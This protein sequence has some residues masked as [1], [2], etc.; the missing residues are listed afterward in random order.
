MKFDKENTKQLLKIIIIGIFVYWILNNLEMVKTVFGNI[1]NVLFPFILGC[2]IAFIFNLPMKFFEKLLSKNKK[3]KIKPKF[4][5]FLSIILSILSIVLAVILLI[6]LIIPQLINVG[7]L[8]IEQIPYYTEQIKNIEDKSLENE[9]IKNI[10]QDIN[11]DTETIRNTLMGNI[12]MLLI[13]SINVISG[14]IIGVANFIISVVFAIYLLLSKEK[15]KDWSKKIIFAYLP[16]KKAQYVL[17]ISRLSSS[18]FKRFIIGQLTEACILGV[19]CFLGMLILRIPYSATVGALVGFTALIPIAG[20]F[21][22][23]TIGALLIVAVDPIK[24]LVFII[25]FLILQQIEGNV[26]YP[27]VVGNSVGL[28][29]MLVL[30]AV[31]V[32]GSLFGIVG[33]LIGLPIVSIIYTILRE[34][35]NMRLKRKKIKET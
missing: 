5:R 17:K 19:L 34:D 25:F 28:P 33:M 11:I 7:T 24:A 13:S 9:T 18:T 10:I 26:I 16:N 32:G 31:A 6:K 15:L 30:F 22:G 1:F 29:G 3:S 8:I 20:A 23:V 27:K 14:M 12:K 35:V 4:K 2:C 21:I